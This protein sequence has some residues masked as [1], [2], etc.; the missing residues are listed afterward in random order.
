MLKI[1]LFLSLY[2]MSAYAQDNSSLGEPEDEQVCITQDCGF[3]AGIS[4]G[5]LYLK[6]YNLEIDSDNS[7]ELNLNTV[8]LDTDVFGDNGVIL[9]YKSEN[10]RFEGLFNFSNHIS[11]IQF[12]I[13]EPRF[14]HVPY[15]DILNDLSFDFEFSTVTG[16]LSVWV[17]P[18]GYW[19]DNV[20]LS[21]LIRPY[22][23]VSTGIAFFDF[24]TGLDQKSLELIS[25]EAT[26]SELE[27]LLIDDNTV[28]SIFLFGGGINFVSIG[29]FLNLGVGYRYVAT[30]PLL[31]KSI[32]E[33]EVDLGKFSNHKIEFSSTIGFH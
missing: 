8:G 5:L 10:I 9:G 15:E 27:D 1:S 33:R 25:D 4:L 18:P 24:D 2:Q 22:I 11:N 13:A 32:S 31:F 19:I 26:I 12:E 6:E 7:Y 16:T 14:H 21:R 28:S 17:E 29:G 23:G 3:Y 30:D 20:K